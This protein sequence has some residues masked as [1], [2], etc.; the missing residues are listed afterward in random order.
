M[1]FEPDIIVTDADS[2]RWRMV[3]EAKLHLVDRKR[4]EAELKRFMLA[5]SAPLGLIVSPSHLAIYRDSFRDFSNDSIELVGDFDIPSE[6]FPFSMGG[7]PAGEHRDRI[8][9]GFAFER[10]VQTWLEEI[11]STREIHGF[12]PEAR[13]ALAEHVLP[14]LSGGMIRAAGPRELKAG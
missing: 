13:K 10:N 4:A 8:E 2:P 6:S 7:D 3:V 14:A 1:S 5:M 11:A 9:T 12:I